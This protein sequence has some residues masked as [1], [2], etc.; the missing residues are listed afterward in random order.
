[1]SVKPLV[2]YIESSSSDSFLSSHG[3]NPERSALIHCIEEYCDCELRVFENDFEILSGRVDLRE[4]DRRSP[5][6]VLVIFKQTRR[7]NDHIEMI[8]YFRSGFER[9][10][11]IVVIPNYRRNGYLLNGFSS[12]RRFARAFLILQT[13][14]KKLFREAGMV[15]SGFVRPNFITK[16]R[17]IFYNCNFTSADAMIVFAVF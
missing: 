11:P 16:V 10:I 1:M 2:I 8:K 6:I 4:E 7:D 13:H 14:N 12:R 9:V 5:R 17:R 3:Y 15:K